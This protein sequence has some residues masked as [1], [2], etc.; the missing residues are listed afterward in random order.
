MIDNR[1]AAPFDHGPHPG[2]AGKGFTGRLHCSES[3]ILS[4]G[5]RQK[6]LVIVNIKRDSHSL[7]FAV[8]DALGGTSP[9][10]CLLQGRKKHGSKNGD[11][12]YPAGAEFLTFVYFFFLII[13]Y[14]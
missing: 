9:F 12:D 14:L 13:K 11:D 8:A 3:G 2:R 5:R 1:H 4:G 6:S 7:L 10:P